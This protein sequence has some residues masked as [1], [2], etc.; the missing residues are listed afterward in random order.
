MENE[1]LSQRRLSRRTMIKGT[2]GTT[3]AIWAAPAVTTL[4]SRAMAAVSLVPQCPQPPVD[5]KCD[6][7]VNCGNSGPLAQCVCDVD[8]E[9]KSFCWENFYCNAATDCATSADCPPGYKCVTTC[10]DIVYGTRTKCAP[11]CGTNVTTTQTT[12]PTAAPAG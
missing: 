6:T 1:K 5:F 9:G 7:V 4:G 8:T 10:C 3:A 11:A 12:G 2:V